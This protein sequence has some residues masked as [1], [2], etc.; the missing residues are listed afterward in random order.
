M[1]YVMSVKY[2]DYFL[3][4]NFLIWATLE[5]LWLTF[6]TKARLSFIC[7]FAC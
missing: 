2:L 3:N 1:L 4:H 5:K 6:D 7:N